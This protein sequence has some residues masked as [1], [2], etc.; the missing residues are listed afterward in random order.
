MYNSR[1]S[2]RDIEH[3]PISFNEDVFPDPAHDEAMASGE[4]VPELAPY[5]PA[6]DPESNIY[7]FAPA[8]AASD[9][10]PAL[11]KPRRRLGVIA[12]GFTGLAL[13]V[14]A[15]W[16]FIELRDPATLPLKAVHI[17][18]AFTH[19]TTAGLQRVIAGATGGGFL[20]ADVAAL[21]RAAL[22]VPWVQSVSVRRVWPDTLYVN[23]TE[24]TP[25]ARW[26]EQ[27][28][29]SSAGKVFSPEVSS[30]PPGLPELHGP[31]GTQATVLAQY[32][33]MSALIAPLQLHI[34][35]LE[36][37]ER[38]A[39]RLSLD[40]GIELLLGRTDSAAHMQRFARVYPSLAAS[41]RTIERVDLR[42]HN[43]LAVRWSGTADRQH[44]D[45]AGL[46]GIT[47]GKTDVK[48]D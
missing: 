18:G 6:A 17:E 7:D 8:S 35:R 34:K 15:A 14:A 9:Q 2:Q 39:W 27:G 25:I 21:R 44:A 46:T 5:D 22:G 31:D 42:Y 30:F 32:R 23:V 11:P 29:L 41:P 19:V 4:P 24:H 28:L 10:T 26:G 37:D 16:G 3:A 40:N 1:N 38:R 48:K 47:Q 45:A 36:L 13:T 43:G 33:S 12:A 20:Y